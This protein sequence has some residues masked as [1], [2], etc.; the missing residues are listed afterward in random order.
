M[1]RGEVMDENG[2]DIAL[3]SRRL[4]FNRLRID[5]MLRSLP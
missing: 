3:E 5:Y 1:G 4:R 2:S